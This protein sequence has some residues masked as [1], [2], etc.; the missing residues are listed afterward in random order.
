MIFS[1]QNI[2]N[3]AQHTYLQYP[4]QPFSYDS[5]GRRY[6]LGFKFKY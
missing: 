2:T 5:S 1:V 3:E 6:F 4:S